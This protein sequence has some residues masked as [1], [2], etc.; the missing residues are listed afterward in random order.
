MRVQGR[1]GMFGGLLAL[2]FVCRPLSAQTQ[3]AAA[4]GV[5]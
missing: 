5:D 1:I 4:L 3:A 2:L